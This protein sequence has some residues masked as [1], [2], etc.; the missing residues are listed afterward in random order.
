MRRALYKVREVS[1]LFHTELRDYGE[2][3]RRMKRTD[4]IASKDFWE[5]S[6]FENSCTAFGLSSWFWFAVKDGGL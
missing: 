3:P 2:A 6:K 5:R 4:Y 1:R